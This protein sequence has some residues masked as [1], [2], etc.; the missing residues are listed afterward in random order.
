MAEQGDSNEPDLA[1]GWAEMQD[2]YG[3]YYINLN[4]KQTSRIKPVRASV[5]QQ[6]LPPPPDSGGKGGD[7]GDLP[8]P[9]DMN[10][11]QNQNQQ[12]N[13]PQSPQAQ[14][15]GN[16]NPQQVM[17]QQM[18]NQQLYQQQW[19]RYYQQQAYQQQMY[20]QQQ[21]AQQYGMNPQQMAQQQ[22][23]GQQYNAQQM[24]SMQ[25]QFPPPQQEQN[26]NED[27]E[28]SETESSSPGTGTEDEDEESDDNLAEN[29]NANANGNGNVMPQPPPQQVMNFQNQNQYQ[30]P[31]QHQVQNS[32]QNQFEMN[33]VQQNLAN[34]NMNQNQNGNNNKPEQNDNGNGNAALRSVP[35]IKQF[36]N[37][38][39][40]NNGT[41]SPQQQQ[42][43]E[44]ILNQAQFRFQ[45]IVPPQINMPPSQPS[46]DNPLLQ[47]NS[48]TNSFGINNGNL[49]GAAN[50]SPMPSPA[51]NPN[52]SKLSGLAAL[53]GQA[54]F[55]GDLPPENN[56]NNTGAVE[57]T[58]FND[59]SGKNSPKLQMA[60]AAAPAYSQ[61]PSD[62]AA[63]APEPVIN[64]QQSTIFGV[65]LQTPDKNK[66]L[67]REDNWDM[68]LEGIE[69]NC[70][71]QNQYS[72]FKAMRKVAQNLLIDDEKY[73]TLYADN[74]MVQ[75]KI[76]GRVGGYEFLRGIGFKQGSDENELVAKNVDGPIV[77][78]CINSLSRKITRLKQTKAQ[79]DPKYAQRKS[80]KQNN[81]NNPLLNNGGHHGG[82]SQAQLQA[83]EDEMLNAALRASQE[84]HVKD[85]LRRQELALKQA[86]QSKKP[87]QNPN[88][89]IPMQNQN[90]N[91]YQNYNRMQPQN[92]YNPLLPPSN[93]NHGVNFSNQKSV[94]MYNKHEEDDHK[95]EELF[96]D[97]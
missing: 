23:M 53:A 58:D 62:I 67:S 12:Q 94:N 82:K 88:Q 49:N 97:K 41:G 54:D 13:V 10:Q 46:N 57:G 69:Q 39:P 77:N 30:P 55:T 60:A 4:T 2:Q 37:A 35:P 7:L 43:N 33:Q 92:Q 65:M 14:A 16:M 84:E 72:V 47:Q 83:E 78:A 61:N 31:P 76:L 24:A 25:Q 3:I 48:S 34:M 26:G 32:G 75:K 64:K 63:P 27:E 40:Q 36:N 42:Q 17:Q 91:Q 28:E 21:M 73:R 6:N 56:N 93:N 80:G 9:P 45:P 5:F 18:Y 22:Q 38:P 8:A 71:I 50:Y 90:Q 15:Y 1:F 20:Q 87:N 68:L 59:K 85:M 86:Q 74:D 52:S 44:K 81:N 79:W 66:H 51:F 29:P 19:Q 70:P 89:Y 11:N 95:A 96:G